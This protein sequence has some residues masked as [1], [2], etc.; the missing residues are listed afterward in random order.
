MSDKPE[1]E[2]RIERLELI[3]MLLCDHASR[4]EGSMGKPF[5]EFADAIKRELVVPDRGAGAQG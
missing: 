2:A 1:L 3:V 5:W 4:G